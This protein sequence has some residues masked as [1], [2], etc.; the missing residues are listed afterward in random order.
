MWK[1]GGNGQEGRGFCPPFFSAKRNLLMGLRPR[2]FER[3]PHSDNHIR[4]P[5]K[6]TYTPMP[7]HARPPTHTHLHPHLPQVLL[8]ISTLLYFVPTSLAVTHQ[9]G[10][11]SLLTISLWFV[12]E[13]KDTHTP[14]HTHKHSSAHTHTHTHTYLPTHP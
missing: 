4:T 9:A 7:A 5:R 3:H 14:T 12:H 2:H 6:N 11:V 1:Q 10:S 13:I 8:G